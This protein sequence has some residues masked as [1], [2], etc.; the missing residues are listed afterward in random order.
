LTNIG[1]NS[2]MAAPLVVVLA[3]EREGNSYVEQT[4]AQIDEE[5]G[6]GLP[7]MVMVDGAADFAA[8]VEARLARVGCTGW[9]VVSLGA[10]RGSTLGMAA[11]LKAAAPQK[12]D[13]LFFEDDVELCRRA[14][15]RMVAVRVPDAS[16]FVTFFDMKEVEP[17]TAAGLYV[18][19]RRG[20]ENEWLFWGCQAMRFPAEMVQWL[21][22]CNWLGTRVGPGHMASDLIVGELIGWHIRRRRMAVHV[23]CLVEH[24]GAVSGCAPG[25]TLTPK[26]LA[27][28][29][30]GKEFDAMTLPAFE[31]AIDEEPIPFVVEP[32]PPPPWHRDNR[33]GLP[34]GGRGNP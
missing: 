8:S 25:L 23:P 24:V 33:P 10:R 32:S 4:A 6:V 1:D 31:H 28:N 17:G 27:T 12:R 21:G 19:P 30:P 5:G 13:V 2:V 22:D 29:Y 20:T 15:E 16:A 3:C 9:E 26:R 14:V 18:R 7:R 34:W 11:A